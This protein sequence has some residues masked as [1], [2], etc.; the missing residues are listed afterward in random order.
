MERWKLLKNKKKLFQFS[1][2]K[3]IQSTYQKF[4]LDSTVKGR[5]KSEIFKILL[6]RNPT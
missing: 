1:I 2:F 6:L 5:F 4:H 3:F